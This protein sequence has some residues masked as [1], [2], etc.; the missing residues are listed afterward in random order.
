[1]SPTACAAKNVWWVIGS[2][3]NES[4]PWLGVGKG[5]HVLRPQT[6]PFVKWRNCSRQRVCNRLPGVCRLCRQAVLA[7][8]R[9]YADVGIYFSRRGH[10]LPSVGYGWRSVGLHSAS[11]WLPL[12]FARS[13]AVVSG[14][15]EAHDKFAAMNG[16]C[17]E[18]ALC[19]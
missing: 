14:V 15:C 7:A 4:Q 19:I 5:S 1:M 11:L 10:T 18:R 3:P 6:V 13:L 16:C 12:P 9:V 8:S 2:S 17:G